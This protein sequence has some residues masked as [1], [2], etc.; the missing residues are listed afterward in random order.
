MKKTKTHFKEINFIQPSV[1]HLMKRVWKLF[2]RESQANK[3]LSKPVKGS[4]MRSL[5]YQA[6]HKEKR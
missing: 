5:D 3:I 2:E 6:L 4:L 1:A